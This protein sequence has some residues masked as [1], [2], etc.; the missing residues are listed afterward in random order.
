MRRKQKLSDE[1]Q[2]IKKRSQEW[3]A[4][5]KRL[6]N[7]KWPH[8]IAYHFITYNSITSWVTRT[9]TSIDWVQIQAVPIP[10]ATSAL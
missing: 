6:G 9:C 10:L 5:A 2:Q 7:E 4:L 3:R 8:F 1:R